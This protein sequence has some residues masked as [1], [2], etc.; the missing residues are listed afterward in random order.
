MT[1]WVLNCHRFSEYLNHHKASRKQ[2]CSEHPNACYVSTFKQIQTYFL[3]GQLIQ[4]QSLFQIQRSPK[5]HHHGQM[6]PV[7]LS[8]LQVICP[9]IVSKQNEIREDQMAK[10]IKA[11]A[12][13][14][15]WHRR[16][17]H[18]GFQHF[19]PCGDVEH[20]ENHRFQ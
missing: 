19:N 5:I 13:T 10:C 20:R 4:L 17:F 7:K 18:G 8:K 3:G 12:P 1:S 11:P 6:L 2:S 16:R 14:R 15:G 9:K